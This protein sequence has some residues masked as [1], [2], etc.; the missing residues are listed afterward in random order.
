MS[1]SG[2]ESTA[3]SSDLPRRPDFSIPPVSSRAAGTAG[4]LGAGIDKG[5]EMEVFEDSW[6]YR[7]SSF[8]GFFQIFP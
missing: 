2:G 8:L 7:Q 4:E 6:G 3:I 1:F 5:I